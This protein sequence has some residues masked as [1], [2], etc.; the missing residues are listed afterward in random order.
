MKA[1]R[2]PVPVPPPT[3]GCRVNVNRA[4]PVLAE[5]RIY[6]INEDGIATVVGLG[7]DSLDILATNDMGAYTLSSIAM[8]GGRIYL[9]TAEALYCIGD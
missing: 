3:R 2:S 4:S 1:A 8:S 5:G 6:I 9:R 7:Q